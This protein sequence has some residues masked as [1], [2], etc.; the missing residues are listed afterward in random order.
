MIAFLLF[1]AAVLPILLPGGI[2]FRGVGTIRGP[3]LLALSG[4]YVVMG[5]G[6]LRRFRPARLATITVAILRIGLAV[7]G[8]RNG[9]L[10]LRV[11]VII[12][13]LVGLLVNG[14]IVWYLLQP[15]IRRYFD[16]PTE[17][18]SPSGDTN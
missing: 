11:V 12:S 7:V 16:R 6:L 17:S 4:L 8:F 10:Q 18:T 2:R 14:L 13:Y 9:I 15:D 3:W 1:L 5:F